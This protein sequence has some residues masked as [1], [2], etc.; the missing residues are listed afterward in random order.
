M[1]RAGDFGGEALAA[2]RRKAP[3]SA[4]KTAHTSAR[5]QSGYSFRQ[6]GEIKRNHRKRKIPYVFPAESQCPDR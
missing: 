4:D 3:D 1:G 5:K 6:S 2:G